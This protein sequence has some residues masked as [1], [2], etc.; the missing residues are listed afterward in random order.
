LGVSHLGEKVEKPVRVGRRVGLTHLLFIALTVSS[1]F[2]IY[3]FYGYTMVV[4][5]LSAYRGRI[6][7]L[8]VMLRYLNETLRGAVP[9]MVVEDV[10]LRFYPAEV[11]REVPEHSIVY[12]SGVASVGK[13][14]KV[15]VRPVTLTLIFDVAPSTDNV[16]FDFYPKSYS[17]HIESP[18][19]NYVEC[20]F[21]I[22]PIYI[23]SEDVSFTVRVTAKVVW[24]EETISTAS[25][26]AVLAIRVR[27]S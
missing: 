16:T 13:L 5:E 19:M 11:S 9:Y 18:E 10:S 24:R 25:T 8:M 3:L 20:P 12:I 22:Y 21:S 7:Q 14:E 15:Q 1:V 2:N 6:D 26:S 4:S 27:E 17:L 23:N